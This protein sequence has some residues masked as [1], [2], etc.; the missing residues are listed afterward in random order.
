MDFDPTDFFPKMK[1]HILRQL[2]KAKTKISPLRVPQSSIVNFL[3]GLP[4]SDKVSEVTKYYSGS[5]PK[6][7]TKELRRIWKEARRSQPTQVVTVLEPAN[8]A[9][10]KS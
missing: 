2:K 1:T 9:V 5:L 4:P 3:K 8:E 10:G 6:H 7:I